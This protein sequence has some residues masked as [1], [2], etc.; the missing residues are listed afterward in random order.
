MLFG[1]PEHKDPGGSDSF[2][3]DGI[4]QR[5]LRELKDAGTD[6]LMIA[7]VCLCEYTDHGHCG[8]LNTGGREDLCR[9]F[10]RTTC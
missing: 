3:K 8:I 6:I 7:D 4:I 10:P 1:I 9:P 2:A 5:A